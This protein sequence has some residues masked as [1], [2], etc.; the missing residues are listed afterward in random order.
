MKLPG[1]VPLAILEEALAA[2]A[3]GRAK[4][5]GIMERALPE[6]GVEARDGC[7]A[8]GGG[9]VRAMAS[10]LGIGI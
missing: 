8:V 10:G 5:R 6:V 1:G 4:L 9:A 2:A 3:R 7:A